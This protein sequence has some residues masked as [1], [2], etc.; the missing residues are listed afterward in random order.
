MSRAVVSVS[1][2][3]K[4]MAEPFLRSRNPLFQVQTSEDG[5]STIFGVLPA[6]PAAAA[7]KAEVASEDTVV[8]LL[9]PNEVVLELFEPDPSKLGAY[10]R[11]YAEAL[12]AGRYRERVHRTDAGE[13]QAYAEIQTSRGRERILNGLTLGVIAK[14]WTKWPWLEY[15]PYAEG[16]T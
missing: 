10:V 12:I 7:L 9:G 6:N 1:A 11:E 4:G 3:L 13:L 15:P 5:P 14:P 2:A 16:D 8:L